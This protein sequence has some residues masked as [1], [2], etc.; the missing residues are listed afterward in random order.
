MPDREPPDDGRTPEERCLDKALK[1]TFPASDPTTAAGGTVTPR[2]AEDQT[3]SD[4]DA[5]RADRDE[6]A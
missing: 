1:A 2:D 5:A 4:A 3:P 6:D